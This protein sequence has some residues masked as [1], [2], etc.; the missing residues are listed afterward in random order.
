MDLVR[1]NRVA[2]EI[3]YTLDLEATPSHSLLAVTDL[4]QSSP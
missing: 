3:P 4:G 1:G 2:I